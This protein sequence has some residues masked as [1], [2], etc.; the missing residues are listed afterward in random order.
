[1]SASDQPYEMLAHTADLK[2]RAYGASVPELFTNALQGMFAIVHPRKK[3]PITQVDREVIVHSSKRAYLLIEFL[4]ECLYL[5]DVHNEA[6]QTAT[7]ELCSDTDVKAI[8]HGYAIS[9]FEGPEIKAVTYHDISVEYI[10]GLWQATVV[11]DI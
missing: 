7:I 6:Y 8:V 2:M 4:A 11:F 3:I 1:M 9:G 10:H 5:S